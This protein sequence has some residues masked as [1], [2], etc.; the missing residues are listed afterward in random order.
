MCTLHALTKTANLINMKRTGPKLLIVLFLMVQFIAPVQAMMAIQV[1]SQ[2]AHQDHCQMTGDS[3]H[4]QAA[5]VKMKPCTAHC[6]TADAAGNADGKD[7]MSSCGGDSSCGTNCNNCSHS[8][9]MV[10]SDFIF[11]HQ[12]ATHSPLQTSYDIFKY[13]PP[14]K[15][16]PPRV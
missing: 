8:S 4:K 5:S 6:L 9:A 2:S 7:H 10:L 14:L 12:A 1:G 15:L 11:I 13:F 16:R 3:S